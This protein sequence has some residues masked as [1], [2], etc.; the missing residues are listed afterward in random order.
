[1]YVA[2]MSGR[3]HFQD[4]QALLKGNDAV[5]RVWRSSSCGSDKIKSETWPTL[6]CV[7]VA[8]NYNFE[9]IPP[10]ILQPNVQL[11]I[12]IAE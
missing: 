6:R 1:M 10:P 12:K 2:M 4:H 8:T 5:S 11:V 3:T 7:E 9:T